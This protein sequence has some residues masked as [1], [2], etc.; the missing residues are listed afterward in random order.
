MDRLTQAEKETGVQGNPGLQGGG[1]NSETAVLSVQGELRGEEVLRLR[2]W[3][4]PLKE[5]TELKN[6]VLNLEK[7]QSI[8]S[9]GLDTLLSL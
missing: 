5:S 3:I 9:E 2:D 7:V 8:D 1:K 4:N 6:I